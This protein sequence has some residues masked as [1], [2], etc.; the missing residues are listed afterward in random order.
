[1][2]KKILFLI[3]MLFMPF[4]FVH[5]IEVKTDW[6]RDVLIS[7][8][9]YAEK[10]GSSFV[11]G[12]NATSNK[13]IDGILF[14]A[15]NNVS[16]KG[17]NEYGLYAGNNIKVN[18]TIQKDLFVAG[19]VIEFNKNVTVGRDAYIAGNKIDI[20]GTITGDLKIYARSVDLSD[21]N[22]TGELYIECESVSIGDNVVVVDKVKYNED[23]V[24]SGNF[25]SNIVVERY[26]PTNYKNTDNSSNKG[27]L[28][29]IVSIASII[30]VALVLNSLFPKINKSLNKKITAKKIFTNMGTGFAILILLPI[31]SVIAMI[32]GVGL[33][34]GL[35][36]LAIYVIALCLA[37]IPVMVIIGENLL[38]SVFK[39]KSNQ[40][41]SI[42]IGVIV[43][44]LISYIPV[45]GGIVYFLLMLVGLGYIKGLMFPKKVNI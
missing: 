3:I 20:S 11:A 25:D 37:L 41:L 8:S 2:K 32:T 10:A 39:L 18:S 12:E 14:A 38:T 43:V 9:P 45:F 13:T 15:G 16:I 23:A 21:V 4:V 17:I 34:I 31:A 42:M 5:A 44:K 6:T 30:I 29:E 33:G 22:V 1:M 19:N 35:L 7:P 40:Y 27:I 36:S 24:V 26:K 28:D